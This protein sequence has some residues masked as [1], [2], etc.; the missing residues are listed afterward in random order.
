MCFLAVLAQAS[1]SK[2][3]LCKWASSGLGD[4]HA[5]GCGKNLERQREK[6]ILSS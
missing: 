1:C 5:L 3:E 4:F 2:Q 6:D